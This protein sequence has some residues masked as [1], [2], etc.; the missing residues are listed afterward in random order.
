MADAQRV[1]ELVFKG[2]DNTAAATQSAISNAESLAKNIEDATAPIIAFT[3]AALKLETALLAA[4]AAVV[5][6]AVKTASDFDTAFR[7]IATLIDIPIGALGDFQAQVKTYAEGSTADF[8]SVTDAIYSAIS[9]GIPYAQSI[10]AVSTA[11]K[12]AVAGKADLNAT[13]VLLVSTLN[14]YGASTEQAGKFSDVF[15]NT[16]KLGQTTLPELAGYM[17]QVTAGAVALNVPIETVAAAI[18]TLT[19]QG[20]ET[21]RAMTALQAAFT[22]LLKPT[23]QATSLAKELGIEIGASAVQSLGFETVIKNMAT[24]TQ[25][26]AE[27]MVIL[28]GSAEAA[29]AILPLAG[30]AADTFATNLQKMANAAG[31]TDDAFAKM[32]GSVDLA[33]QQLLNSI[34]GLLIDVGTPL[35]DEFS[36]TAKSLVAIFQAVGVQVKEDGLGGLTTY[37]EQLAQELASTIGAI[38]ANL[39]AALEAADLS[40]FK[41]GIQTVIDAFRELFGNIDITTVEGLTKAIETA[42]T[43]FLGLSKFTGGVITS[44]EPLLNKLL[45]LGEGA[46][47]LD[48]SFAETAGSIAGFASQLGYIAGGVSTLIPAVE[49][50]VAIMAVKQGFNLLSAMASVTPA[51]AALV[52]V[53]TGPVGLAVA[54]GAAAIAAGAYLVAS[55]DIEEAN[56]KAAEATGTYKEK[57]AELSDKLKELSDSLG[58]PIRSYEEFDALVKAGTVTWDDAT[59]SWTKAADAATTLGEST[60]KT[61]AEIDKHNAA[62]L[63]A[64][65]ATESA[66][67]KQWRLNDATKG[68]VPIID[69]ATGAII[70]YEGTLSKVADTG[71]TLTTNADL[72]KTAI[73]EVAKA[74]KEAEEAQLKWNL[75]IEKLAS[76]EFIKQLESYT[77]ITTAQIEADAQTI[78][79]AF[80]SIG[81][82]VQATGNTIAEIVKSIGGLVPNTDAFDLVERQLEIEN[83]RQD[84]NLAL[85]K[86]LTEAQVELIRKRTEALTRGDAL[87]KIEGAGLQPHL[88]AFM[89]EILKAIQ[90]KVN[91]DGLEMLVGGA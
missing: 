70:G 81:V 7:E 8:K 65:A 40:G 29:R 71:T 80:D 38:A 10:E 14:A 78:S 22:S 9:A 91:Q 50:L 85:Q 57:T 15:F 62:L 25:G 76:A 61:A 12:L 88:E 69:E 39:P 55:S 11:E 21:P 27:K 86:E 64:S 44:F 20:L 67:I 75:E 89:W 18:A 83:K 28:A 13:L 24:A 58:I 31:A 68:I 37:I 63:A 72:S 30:S 51:T 60:G 47:K 90:T 26:S 48:T 45:E 84:E 34:K 42:G 66:E 73:K 46:G 53:I 17:G 33:T 52:S 35:L 36:S 41:N 3:G 16:V 74:V 56:K 5:G 54:L 6:F 49:G 2:V 79:S 77:K 4:G 23:E 82:S 87:I 32:T 1:I 19:A 59:N 43:A